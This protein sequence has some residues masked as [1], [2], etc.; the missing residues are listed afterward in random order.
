MPR[1]AEQDFSDSAPQSVGGGLQSAYVQ[2]LSIFQYDSLFSA[3][4]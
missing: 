1:K 4:Y 2:I 3:D